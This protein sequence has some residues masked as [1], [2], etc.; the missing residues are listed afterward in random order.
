MD[1]RTVTGPADQAPRS[2]LAPDEGAEALAR[3]LAGRRPVVV[4]SGAGL[5]TESGIPDYRGVTGRQRRSVP[6]T[7]Q[8]FTADEASRRRGSQRPR[9]LR[10]AASSSTSTSAHG[11]DGWPRAWATNSPR[12]HRR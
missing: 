11:R 7:F 10:L 5:S 1:I 6:M 9:S 8:E 4:L 2:P 12:N 3:F